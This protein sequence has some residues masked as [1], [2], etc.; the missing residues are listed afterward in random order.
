MPV[1]GIPLPDDAIL[2]SNLDVY[3]CLFSLPMNIMLFCVWVILDGNCTG[4][5]DPFT[6]KFMLQQ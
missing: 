2:R 6:V 3:A 4:L 1:R 5:D